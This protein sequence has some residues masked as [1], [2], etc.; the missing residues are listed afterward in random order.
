MTTDNYSTD[1]QIITLNGL[2][3]GVENDLLSKHYVSC[4]KKWN[5]L[6]FYFMDMSLTQKFQA[7]GWN[8]TVLLSIGIET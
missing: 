7:P 5:L 3:V 6:L 2:I 4:D 1:F 8:W